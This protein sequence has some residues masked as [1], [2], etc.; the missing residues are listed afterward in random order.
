MALVAVPLA[1]NIGCTSSG[2][3]ATGGTAGDG[4]TGG[5]GGGTAPE[6]YAA[7]ICVG[8]KQAAAG[9]Y[10]TAAFEAWATWAGDQDDSARDAAIDVASTTLEDSWQG[11]ETAAEG[12]GANCSDSAW[13]ASSAADSI[14]T[15]IDAIAQ[16]VTDG[17]DLG[18]S[19][20][21]TCAGDILDASG[22][23]CDEVLAAEGVH[24]GDLYAD[25]D[26]STLAQATEDAVATFSEAW[27]AATSGECPT[28]ATEESVVDELQGVV[29]LAVTNTTVT[30]GLS[31]DA[32]TALE[33]GQTEYLGRTYDPQCMQGD[34]YRF[35]GRRG[36]VN[37]LVMYYMGGGACWNNLTCGLPTCSTAPPTDL[38]GLDSGFGDFDNPQNPFRDWHFVF[39]SYCSCD[40]HFGD[41]TQEYVG[42]EDVTVEHKGF[43]NAKVAERWA[44]E[45]FLNP[46]EVFVTGSSA[47]SYGALFNAPLL[48]DV[49]PASQF[50]ILGDA[51]NGVI[52]TDFLQNEFSNWNFVENLPDIPGVVESITEGNGM[53][54]YMESV[55]DYL[56]DTNW[57]NYSTMFDGGSGGQT[58]FFNMMLNDGNPL[59][60]QVWWEASC[61]F[62]ETALAQSDDIYDTVPDNYRYYFGTGSRHTM[63]GNDKVYDDTTGNVPTV[64]S[65]VEAML[66]SGPDG[67]D[68]DWTNILCEDCGLTLAGDPA[69]SPLEAP[70]EMRGED[71]VIVCE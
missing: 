48:H 26:G 56:P 39:V 58:G 2:D 52:T 43:H 57:A 45:H 60:A 12:A 10:C 37:K 30:P 44:R 3:E 9:E 70:F 33:P 36:T 28:N 15:A 59:A 7:N 14:K 49:W 18:M 24:V 41:A 6:P 8:A 1:F 29:V 16:S 34:Q 62:G 71:I 46:E 51:G 27:A 69:P 63:F 55:A 38:D 42:F 47:G 23:A 35:F 31:S 32:F 64:V 17:L 66:A 50:H 25:M 68:P 11:A 5:D 40:I 22:A 19:G 65:W 13:P 53:P 20:H 54:G 61:Q 4:G 21:A 67:R